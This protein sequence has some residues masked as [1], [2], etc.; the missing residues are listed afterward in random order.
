MSI[1]LIKRKPKILLVCK[2]AI[3]IIILWF[4][5]HSTQLKPELFTQLF[6]QPLLSLEVVLVLL[7]LIVIGAWRWQILNASQDIHL[8]FIKTLSA[9]Y[10]GAAFNYVLPGSVGGDLIRMYYVF[11][12]KPQK[13]GSAML[14]VFFDRVMGFVAVF[15]IICLIA[16]FK[17]DTVMQHPQLFY[18]LSICTVFCFSILS[19]FLILLFLP[20]KVNFLGWFSRRSSVLASF[21]PARNNFR[22]S[23]AVFCK[24][25]LTSILS[26]VLMVCAVLLIARIMN[27]PPIAFSD[28]A[29]AMGMTQI[30]NLIPIT[31]GG[32]G[33]GEMMFAHTLQLLN[34]GAV[35]AFATIFFTYRIISIVTYLPGVV[36][37][38][39]RFILLKQQAE[40]S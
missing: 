2:I 34:P 17:M 9:T 36:F 7:S 6:H 14:S 4:L 32:V 16:L 26:Q 1:P 29:L 38:I 5:I 23:K 35:G 27:L 8:S 20:G 11:K 22:L 40:V 30:V 3:S 33:I 21:L 28:Y 10:L 37:Y 19:I 25:L 12:K 18:L 31:P 24:C 15:L 13:K 39:P